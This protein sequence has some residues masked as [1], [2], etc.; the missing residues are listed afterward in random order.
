MS[1]AHARVCTP[2]TAGTDVDHAVPAEAGTCPAHAPHRKAPPG[3]VLLWIHADGKQGRAGLEARPSVHCAPG[4]AGW[5]AC[6][7]LRLDGP[8][9][10]LCWLAGWL[11]GGLVALVGPDG[12]AGLAG[13]TGWLG[14]P[15]LAGGILNDPWTLDLAIVQTGT[16][17]L[18]MAKT[19]KTG[20]TDKTCKS[21][22]N[23][24]FSNGNDRRLAAF[25]QFGPFWPLLPVNTLL[26]AL[27]PVPA[28]LDCS[29]PRFWRVWP[30]LP[31]FALLRVFMQ[32][33]ADLHCCSPRF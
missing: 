4:H 6:W 5:I 8:D 21:R 32:G 13:W 15:G 27:L 24:H 11:A 26:Y 16:K 23:L 20:K 30:V 22:A 17:G 31:L 33:P 7:V 29:S 19:G 1:H 2:G 12:L 10:R 18:I 28:H 25:A 9:G 14:W 3:A